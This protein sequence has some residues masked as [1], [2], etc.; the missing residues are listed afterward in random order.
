[1]AA[2]NRIDEAAEIPIGAPPIRDGFFLR[3]D[4]PADVVFD[5]SGGLRFT[6]YACARAVGACRP[7]SVENGAYVS[8]DQVTGLI[9][10]MAL[11]HRL[12]PSGVVVEGVDLRQEAAAITHRMI[13]HLRAHGWRVMDPTG[14]S[15]PDQWGGNALGFS[16]LF[17]RAANHIC[18]GRFGIEDYRD[19]RSETL[20]RA[21]FQGMLAIWDVTHGYNRTMALRLM[22]I[23]GGWEADE[24]ASRSVEDHKEIYALAYALIHNARLPAPFSRWRMERI[25]DSAP[26]GGPCYNVEGC[27][28]APG[29]RGEHR[30]TGPGDRNGCKHHR[31]A[32]FNGLDY[33]LLH[34]LYLLYQ[35]GE[36]GGRTPSSADMSCDGMTDLDAILAGQVIEVYE[37]CLASDMSRRFCGRPW[38]AWLADAFAGEVTIFTGGVGGRR[39]DCVGQTCALVEIDYPGTGGADLILGTP[40]DDHLRGGDGDDCIYGFGGA[41]VLR[42]ERGNDVLYGGEGDDEIYGEMPGAISGEIDVLYGEGG[43]DTLK[44]GPGAD[45]LYGGEGADTLI[46]DGG[47]DLIEG[48]PGDDE[49]HGDS[50][51]D[52]IHGN[53][54]DD[55]LIGD[56]GDDA[57]YGQ[58]GR[59]KLD[60]E[61]GDDWLFGGAGDNLLKGGDGS[62]RLFASGDAERLCGNGGDDELWGDWDGDACLGGGWFMGGDD[63]VNGCEDGTAS[64][65][66]C[67][68]SAFEDW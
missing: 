19:D 3:D 26:C 8:Q 59:D 63:T 20:G 24:M 60:G 10:G 36:Y 56:A 5:A 58:A 42:G 13:N 68:N 64:E 16:D 29:W 9:F 44:G 12:V 57:L 2:F 62:D 61:G 54:G 33:L 39:W 53:D 48:G 14:E 6:G 45:E 49:A 38:S 67:D 7:P 43:A 25:L 35:G 47:D 18:E 41:D 23:V 52:V 46:G 11:I 66:D 27:E 21:A 28:E 55:T 37:P 51:E 40:G 4:V 34:H 65:D 30:W 31:E 15:P 32:E 50:G 1:L 17:A 22:A